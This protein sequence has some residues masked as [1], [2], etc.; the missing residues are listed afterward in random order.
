MNLTTIL[1][2]AQK[3][4]N[5]PEAQAYLAARGTTPEQA[6]LYGVGYFPE[7]EWPPYVG[8]SDDDDVTQYLK[9]SSRG[10]RMRGKLVFPMTNPTGRLVGIQIRSP[11]PEKKDYSKYYLSESKRDALF[12]G[13]QQALPHIW[14]R[15]E[16]YLVEG[17]FDLFPLQRTYPNVICTGTARIDKRQTDFLQRFCDDVVIAFDTDWRGNQ[18]FKEF[19]QMH[20]KS[21][22]S[23]RRLTLGAKDISEAWKMA[24]S[25]QAFQENLRLRSL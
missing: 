16:V 25:D 22:R 15:R 10:F 3:N 11:N 24:V 17:L 2:A 9:W 19:Q 1:K 4:R 23:I 8:D 7:D 13:T 5:H 12:F 14:E 20:Q 6:S 21:F 18:T